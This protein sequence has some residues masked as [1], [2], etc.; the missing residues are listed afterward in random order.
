MP[1]ANNTQT[2]QTLTHTHMTYAVENPKTKG[3]NSCQIRVCSLLESKINSTH[4][5]RLSLRP[6]AVSTQ[7]NTALSTNNS[8]S[9]FPLC[10]KRQRVSVHPL[11]Y[12]HLK[13]TTKMT[14]NR[15]SFTT[16]FRVM[17]P[18][19]VLEYAPYYSGNRRFI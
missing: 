14:L 6:T 2:V 13:M 5:Q 19:S 17:F 18:S 1:S 9:Y 10:T 16:P 4:L 8:N 15:R 3:M 11:R 7:T 12:S